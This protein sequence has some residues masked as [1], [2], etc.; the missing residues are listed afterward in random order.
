MYVFEFIINV[1]WSINDSII[2]II[3][4]IFSILGVI[5]YVRCIS[6]KIIWQRSLMSK[7]SVFNRVLNSCAVF[8]GNLFGS[9]KKKRKTPSLL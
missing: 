3:I 6:I 2:I 8:R 5:K 4:I 9:K 7:S 1:Y